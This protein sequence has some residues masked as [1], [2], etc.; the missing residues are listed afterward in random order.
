MKTKFIGTKNTLA[1]E[2]F[3][4]NKEKFIGRAKFWV[5]GLFFGSL[6]DTIFFDGYL[7]GGLNEILNKKHL[8]QRY[9]LDNY[10]STYELLE[11]DILDFNGEEYELAESFNVN[12]GTWSDYFNIYSYKLTDEIGAILW[13]FVDTSDSLEDLIDYPKNIF[14]EEFSYDEL[15]HIVNNLKLLKLDQ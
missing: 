7:I 15:H 4:E 12:L 11:A 8:N 13:K 5:N 9:L 14:Y 3:F 2:Y 10:C 1:V 6:N